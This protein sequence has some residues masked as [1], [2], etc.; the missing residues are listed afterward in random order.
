[1]R[2]FKNNIDRLVSKVLNEEIENKVK[3]ISVVSGPGEPGFIN[4]GEATG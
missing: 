1:M 3:Q 4:A 2:N